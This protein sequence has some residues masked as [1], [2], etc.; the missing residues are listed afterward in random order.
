MS[1]CGFNDMRIKKL[2]NKKKLANF[3]KKITNSLLIGNYLKVRYLKKHAM[4]HGEFSL[5]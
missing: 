2:K 1:S 5:N 4:V 3:R